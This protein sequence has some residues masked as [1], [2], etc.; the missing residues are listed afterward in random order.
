VEEAAGV[1]RGVAGLAIESYPR[2]VTLAF[3]K[4][5]PGERVFVDW[6]R[7]APYST[8]VA[9]WSLRPRDGAPVA[10]PVTWKELET[11]YPD[12]IRMGD[13]GRRLG[14][15][16]WVDSLDVSTAVNDVADAIASAGIVL[17]P[18]DRFRS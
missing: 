17:E 15:D 18:F 13:V 3:R 5:P 16:P 4:K 2:V 10:A 11:I 8:A 6:M 1:A 9:P 7:N 12:A 14:E